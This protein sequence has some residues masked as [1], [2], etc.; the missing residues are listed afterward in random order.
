MDHPV[1][2]CAFEITPKRIEY[3]RSQQS[4]IVFKYC[5]M[6]ESST[7]SVT[8]IG[9]SAVH[10]P[11]IQDMAKELF[12]DTEFNF[13]DKWNKLQRLQYSQLLEKLLE[14]NNPEALQL[15]ELMNQ[16]QMYKKIWGLIQPYFGLDYGKVLW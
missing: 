4:K 5:P 9:T 10:E 3:T 11:P 14:Q 13:S 8:C 2:S 7:P 16:Q 1:F 15:Q 6:E 12:D